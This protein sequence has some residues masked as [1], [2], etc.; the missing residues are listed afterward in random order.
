MAVASPTAAEPL[1]KDD[2]A[3]LNRAGFLLA[4]LLTQFDKAKAA[5]RDVTDLEMRRDDLA[6][7]VS[8]IKGA[9][10]PNAK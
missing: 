10:F 6:N 1:T 7:Q 5:G 4:D 2:L 3:K 9:Y 8:L